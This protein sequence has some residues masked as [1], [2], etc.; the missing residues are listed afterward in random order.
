MTQTHKLG[1]SR[2]YLVKV[3]VC[4]HDHHEQVPRRT[5][6]MKMLDWLQ[7]FGLEMLC[8]G[9]TVTQQLLHDLDKP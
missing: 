9:I 7:N 1:L 6:M 2:P 3:Y 8:I 5:G 4:V